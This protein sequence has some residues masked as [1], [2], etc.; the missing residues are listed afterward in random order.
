MRNQ[1]PVLGTGVFPPESIFHRIYF[2][3]FSDDNGGFIKRE[4][5]NANHMDIN[6][7]FKSTCR[8]LFKEE[9]GEMKEFESFLTKYTEKLMATKSISGKDVY[10]T[11]PY[12]KNAKF[13]SFEEALDSEISRPMDINDIK[14]I[15]SLASAASERFHYTGNKVLG[16]SKDVE[17]SE[18]ITDCFV[19]Y[20]SSEILRCEYVAYSSLLR[21][22][23]YM[24]GCSCLGMSSFYINVCE[25][26]FSQR[27]FECLLVFYSADAYYSNNCKSCQDIFFCF[28]QQSK[29]NMIGNIALD[30]DKYKELKEKLLGQIADELKRKKKLLSLIDFIKE[31]E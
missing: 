4:T 22:S 14:D 19:V 12:C 9:V 31:G 16:N 3:R 10:Y 27:C 24:F 23:K 13:L 17:Q 15:D 29:R 6:S 11:A 2:T 21:D 18:N 1:F 7:V 5:Y 28:D 26:N 30:K 25:S 20:Q 8:V